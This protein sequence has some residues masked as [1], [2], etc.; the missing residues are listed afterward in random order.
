MLTFTVSE[1]LGEQELSKQHVVISDGWNFYVIR[2]YSVTC[3][4]IVDVFDSNCKFLKR[5]QLLEAGGNN[6]YI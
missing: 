3:N 2:Q 6:S 4:L 1:Y 5:I